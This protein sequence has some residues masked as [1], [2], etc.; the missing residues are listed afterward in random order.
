LRCVVLISGPPLPPPGRVVW[1]G[2][3]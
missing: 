3:R 1:L 2:V